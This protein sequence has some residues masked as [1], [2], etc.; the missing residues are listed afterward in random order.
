M[1]ITFLPEAASG[2]TNGAGEAA[3]H[4]SQQ[5][6]KK[7]QGKGHK[8]GDRGNAG[9]GWRL[10]EGSGER[11]LQESSDERY[12][13]NED[14]ALRRMSGSVRSFTDGADADRAARQS[15][16][17]I[18]RSSPS[19]NADA[20]PGNHPNTITSFSNSKSNAAVGSGNFGTPQMA[21]RVRSGPPSPPPPPP[22]TS[23]PSP[24]A[25]M[26][27]IPRFFGSHDPEPWPPASRLLRSLLQS[28]FSSDL[29]PINAL[30]GGGSHQ[31][32]THSF[33]GSG[34]EQAMQR[35]NDLLGQQQDARKHPCL[36]PG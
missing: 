11:R 33:L 21:A 36:P 22:P 15:V 32:Y 27:S 5:H 28:D 34:L 7:K 8:S 35:S 29:L 9:A 20:A 30:P 12:D 10:A 31:L 24:A 19:G 23:A 3:A 2:G 4:A 17:N 26:A 6:Q 16:T 14:K 1:Q 13:R 18:E 25:P